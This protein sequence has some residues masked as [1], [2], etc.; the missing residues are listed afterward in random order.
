VMISSRSS[1]PRLGI[2]FV[3]VLGRSIR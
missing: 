3:A 2:E 1:S